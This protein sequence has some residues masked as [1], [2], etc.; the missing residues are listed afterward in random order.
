MRVTIGASLREAA[1]PR[2]GLWNVARPAQMVGG[3]IQLV[4]DY[5]ADKAAAIIRELCIRLV[6]PRFVCELLLGVIANQANADVA[7][8]SSRLMLLVS[9]LES[10][11][12]SSVSFGDPNYLYY[13]YNTATHLAEKA[14]RTA[15]AEDL[16][17]RGTELH[18]RVAKIAG[19]GVSAG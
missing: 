9:D 12:V 18:D 13:C 3:T 2:H 19:M 5:G 4:K 10:N 6:I 11:L 16:F 1:L 7:E 15:S 14:G 17:R 8:W